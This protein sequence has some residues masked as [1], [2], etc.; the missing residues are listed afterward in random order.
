MSVRLSRFKE[1]GLMSGSLGVDTA[2]N[3]YTHAASAAE[4]LPTGT[5]LNPEGVDRVFSEFQ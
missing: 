5:D 2:R 1:A 3:T 4:V